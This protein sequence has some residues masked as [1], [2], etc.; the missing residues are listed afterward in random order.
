MEISL[1]GSFNR[2]KHSRDEPPLRSWFQMYYSS[3]VCARFQD[4]NFND[5]DA[6]KYTIMRL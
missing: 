6:W 1:F 2:N 5:D 3:P 4:G